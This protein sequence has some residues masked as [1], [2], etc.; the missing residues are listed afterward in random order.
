MTSVFVVLLPVGVAWQVDW[1]VDYSCPVASGLLLCA[2]RLRIAAVEGIQVWIN[3]QR[4][5]V[6]GLWRGCLQS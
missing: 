6:W 2:E 1:L 5:L 4:G 3:K